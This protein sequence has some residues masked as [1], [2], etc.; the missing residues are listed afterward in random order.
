MSLTFKDLDNFIVTAESKTLSQA[1]ERLDISQPTLSLGVQKIE[2]ELGYPLFIRSREGIKLTPHGKNLLPEAREA[3]AI[4]DKIKGKKNQLKFRIGCHP[5]VGMFVLGSFLKIMHKEDPS[6]G[7]EILNAA[8]NDINKMVAQGTVD[9]GIVMNPLQIQGLIIKT[10]GEDHVYVWESKQRYQDRLIYN[11]AMLQAHSI[12]SR[13]KATPK[14][15][16]EV[17]NL[18]LVAH[19]TDS[20]AGYGILPSQVVKAQKLNLIKLPGTPTF[21]DHLALVC[22]PEMLKTTEGKLIFEAL[23]SSYRH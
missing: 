2:E 8:S 6:L 14:E 17:Q 18:E 9:F 10:I 3:I 1:A 4:L 7:I 19:L 15:K 20:G 12:M 13:W 22:Y 21:K 23:K 11:P 16:I 5:S